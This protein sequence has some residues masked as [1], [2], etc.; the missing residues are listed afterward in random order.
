VPQVCA[1]CFDDPDIQAF[2]TEHDDEPGCDFCERDDAPTIDLDTLCEYLRD[3]LLLFFGLAN[4]TL[5]R[6]D[7]S[8]S[9]FFGETWETDQLLFGEMALELPRDSNSE[10]ARALINAVDPQDWWCELDPGGFSEDVGLLLDWDRFCRIAKKYKG[11]LPPRKAK[12]RKAWFDDARTPDALL[13]EIARLIVSYNLI[14]TLPSGTKIYRGRPNEKGHRYRTPK[15]LGPP[16]RKRAMR[17]NR[18]NR[19]GDPMFYGADRAA[20]VDAELDNRESMIGTFTI[21]RDIRLLDLAHLPPAPGYFSGADREDVLFL[22]FLHRFAELISLPIDRDGRGADDYF[23]TQAFTSG[24]RNR[25]FEGKRIDGIRYRS[26]K[27]VRGTNIVLFATQADLIGA[28]RYPDRGWIKLKRARSRIKA[29]SAG[30]R[31]DRTKADQ[32]RLLRL[33]AKTDALPLFDGNDA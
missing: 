32:E 33:A 18:M 12:K 29:I 26:A 2:I 30:A 7:E 21:Q 17:P 13:K 24:V 3:R 6:D 14:T 28:G 15:T 27:R 23:P 16:S 5:L 1:N 25:L 19:P 31:S 10:L 4:G 20:V 22:I 11:L 8:E 9:G